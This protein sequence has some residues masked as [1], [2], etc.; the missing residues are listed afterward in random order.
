MRRRIA[1]AA[2]FAV[3]LMLALAACTFIT[4]VATGL[5]YDPSDGVSIDVGAVQL[6]NAFVVS[7]D[8]ES[9]NFVGV[10]INSS[11][12]EKD[13]TIQ[14][15]SHVDNKTANTDLTVTLPAGGVISYGD[16]GT[17]QLQLQAINV[18]PGALLKLFVQYGSVSGKTLRVPVL[19]SAQQ[20]Y[21]NLTPT[22]IPPTPTACPTSSPTD[23]PLPTPDATCV[24]DPLKT[25]K[26]VTN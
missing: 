7:D 20:S 15:V 8:G 26:P 2:V 14:Y 17:P 25:A 23:S 16:P 1:A 12:T 24:P 4:P 18:Q 21:R 5:A 9:A 3:G 19:T 13:V 11:D 22:P 10:L 6:R